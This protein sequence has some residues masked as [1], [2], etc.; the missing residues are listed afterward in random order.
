MKKIVHLLFC[1]SL[2]AAGTL[3][4][5]NAGTVISNPVG[6][7]DEDPLCPCD[8][9]HPTFS[10]GVSGCSGEFTSTIVLPECMNTGFPVA[11]TW[12]VDGAFA[13]A[14][15]TLNYTFP[16]SGIYNLC[17][18]VFVMLPNEETCIQEVCR[19]VTVEECC[20]C[21]ALLPSF[22][23]SVNGCN[24][25]FEST[26]ILLPCM[27]VAAHVRYDWTVNGAAAGSGSSLNYTFPGNGT[28]TVCLTVTT[29]LPD[30]NDCIKQV[31][32]D[33]TVEEC[34]PCDALLP[35]F[36]TSLNGCDGLFESTS[37]IPPCME[38]WAHVR[39]DWTVNGIAA[40]SGSSFAYTFPGSGTY[41]VCLTVTTLLPDGNDCIK[42]ICQEVTVNCPDSFRLKGVEKRS[43]D[44]SLLLYPNPA[45][46]E[47]HI[48][49][50]L[51]EAGEVN[52]ALKSMDGKTVLSEKRT[53]AAG[54]QEITVNIPASVANTVIFLE[55]TAGTEKIVRKVTVS[56]K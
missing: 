48:E 39:Y 51:K 26:S 12:L 52:I 29:L 50:E 32:Y 16:G 42:T 1:L 35:S 3:Y 40:G 43:M 33:V 20:P 9:L 38:I 22:S 8:S 18:R 55:L 31:C 6:L 49:L 41:T 24:G 4:A 44:K 46:D 45:M 37:T 11:Y 28:Y 47:L 54:K 21:D 25:F 36:S 13:G 19:T 27:E 15:A 34:C 17:M 30:A 56:G 14:G 53:A 7:I 5:G 2:V 23:T 10:G